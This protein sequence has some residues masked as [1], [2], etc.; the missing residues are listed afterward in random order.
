MRACTM[1]CSAGTLTGILVERVD[2]EEE[3]R[4]VQIRAR[5]A[6]GDAELLDLA[7]DVHKAGHDLREADARPTCL[8]GA[9]QGGLCRVVRGLERELRSTEQVQWRCI[10]RQPR[11]HR[12]AR[13][14]PFFVA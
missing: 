1:R 7:A 2:A 3:L 12:N 9:Q 13:R 14:I 10:A 5:L 8:P 11:R 4:V 6:R